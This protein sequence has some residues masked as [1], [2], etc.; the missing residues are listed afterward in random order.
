M[1]D[2][3]KIHAND[4]LEAEEESF[5]EIVIALVS[6]VGTDL[7]R[8]I[9]LMS[10]ELELYDFKPEVI[11]VSSGFL[12]ALQPVP[13]GLSKLETINYFMNLGNQYRNVTEDNA[14]L[15]Y[16]AI[17]EISQRRADILDG[18]EPQPLKKKAWII[19][20]LK[21]PDEVAA[22]RETYGN[23][24]FV[25]GIHAS[26][27]SR[28]QSLDNKRR[29]TEDSDVVKKLISRDEDEGPNNGHGQHTR[30]TFH[31]ADF[32]IDEDQNLNKNRADVERVFKLIFGYPFLT[33]T[34]DEYAMYMAFSA[35][36]RSADLSRQVGAVLTKDNNIISTG[37]NDVPRSKGGLYWPSLDSSN[38]RIADSHEGRDYMRGY[39]ANKKAIQEVIDDIIDKLELESS[40]ELNKKLKNTKLKD[41]TEYGRVVHAEME[42]ILS[43]GRT[44][45][46]TLETTLYCTTFPCHN[47]AKHIIA[48]GVL[49]VVYVEPYAKS[50]AFEFHSDAISEGYCEDKVSFEP[51]VGV[52]PRSF[53]NFFS[54]TLGNGREIKRK[55]SS[56]ET[57]DWS[58]E[59]AKL[60]L[61]PN[62]IQYIASEEFSSALT[63]E[64]FKIFNDKNVN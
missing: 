44:N 15:A 56:G 6:A 53:L 37:A 16:A 29:S 48:A 3:N 31:L 7:S 11:R 64:H 26:Y 51:F 24:L 30:D 12:Q 42:A 32:F 23:S 58:R 27:E 50:K 40:A 22:L 43:C 25:I 52:G 41:I 5:S 36:S 20:S 28:F 55:K 54:M 1:S 2:N 49:R 59:S 13:E 34:F 21:H 57:V 45:N 39:D 18:L 14:A 60:R 63:G 38:T 10:D 9:N 17:T 35:S 61:K 47:C 8:F 33:P 4:G 19:R 46:S 62:P